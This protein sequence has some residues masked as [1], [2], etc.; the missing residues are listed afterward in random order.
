MLACFQKWKIQ[1]GLEHQQEMRSKSKPRALQ[2][3]DNIKYNGMVLEGFKQV[4]A[5]SA[6]RFLKHYFG[7]P[8]G[9]TDQKGAKVKQSDQLGRRFITEV[10]MK[11]TVAWSKVLAVGVER[12]GKRLQDTLWD[13]WRIL[14]GLISLFPK[15]YLFLSIYYFNSKT[16]NSEN[17]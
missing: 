6:L 4:V 9:Q 11:M 17:G 5:W 3:N 8:A 2:M 12:C 14:Y 1:V 13:G 7:L 15:L 10:K 16:E